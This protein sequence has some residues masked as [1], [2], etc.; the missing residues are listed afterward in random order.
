[1]CSPMEYPKDGLELVCVALTE[2]LVELQLVAMVLG[3]DLNMGW[4]ATVKGDYFHAARIPV[5]RGR[6][7]SGFPPLS[8]SGTA[9]L[10]TL[11]AAS[12]VEVV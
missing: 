8:E 1:M 12:R 6:D 4:V 7:F 10:S 2:F 11:R 5:I 9:W 3:G